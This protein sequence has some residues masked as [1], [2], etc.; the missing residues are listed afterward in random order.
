MSF[1]PLKLMTCF[2][3]LLPR[4]AKLFEQERNLCIQRRNIGSSLATSLQP[5]PPLSSSSL[6]GIEHDAAKVQPGPQHPEETFAKRGTVSAG[7]AIICKN[8][9]LSLRLQCE[10][11]VVS[12]GS[13][14]L[15]TLEVRC[16]LHDLDNP[17]PASCLFSQVPPQLL[18]VFSWRKPQAPAAHS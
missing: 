1:H 5:A 16:F 3:P 13:L 4:L 10:G 14:E 17:G 8:L 7:L 2:P 9:L 18:P 15:Q 11:S 12:L 6:S